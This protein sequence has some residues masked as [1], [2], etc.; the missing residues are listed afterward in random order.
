[1]KIFTTSQIREIDKYTIDHEPIASIDLMERAADALFGRI[2]HSISSHKRIIVF[3][4]PGNNGGDGLA[5]ARMMH[6]AGY[7]IEVYYLQAS[8]Y[9]ADFLINLDRIKK[10]SIFLRVISADSDFPKTGSD[11]IIVDALYGSGLARPLDGVADELV[12]YLNASD[13]KVISIDIPSGLFGDINPYPNP[14]SV[15][16]ADICL[17]LQ[18]PKKSFFFP[19][20][21]RFFK[22]WIVLPIGLHP[23]TIE[24]TATPFYY[25][26]IEEIKGIIVPRKTFS[27]KGTYGHSLIV[28]GSMGM[29]GAA[30][31]CTLSAVKSGSGLVTMHIPKCGYTIAQQIVPMAM[32]RVDADEYIVKSVPDIDKFNSI[33]IGPGLGTNP[34]TVKALKDLITRVK[35]PLLLDAD[36]LNIIS[37]S[38]E[39]L[40]ALPMN[41]IIT[42]HPGEF[43]RL[44]GKSS[45]GAERMEKAIDAAKKFKLIIVLKGAYTQ[46]INSDGSVSFNST[47]N[48]GMATGGSGDVLSGII[49]GLLAQGYSPINSAQLG[50]F[51]HGLAGDIAEKKLGQCSLSAEN[52]IESLPLAFKCVLE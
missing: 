46:I 45:C 44:F 9:S 47:G 39:L 4:G 17:T 49:T 14:N 28:A 3:C 31:L 30:S 27:H 1:M 52:I 29:M 2:V 10:T 20:N 6:Y 42:P 40:S 13:A 23:K 50:V 41:T 22:Q 11:S 21:E 32:C 18:F 5:L 38:K 19:E 51:L 26:G 37:E 25:M 36:A 48:A 12:K 24:N 8:N 15:I 16:E 33:C 7:N 34:L 35:V 43:D